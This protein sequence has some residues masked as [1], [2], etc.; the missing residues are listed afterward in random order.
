MIVCFLF[1]LFFTMI[2][3][4]LQMV[5]SALA[6]AQSEVIWYIQHVGIASSKSK[7]LRPVP[8]D[9]VSNISIRYPSGVAFFFPNTFLDAS[10]N[11]YSFSMK[12]QMESLTMV[13]MQDATDPTIGFLLDGIDRLCC[14][15]RKYIAG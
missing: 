15:V 4:F 2:V 8:V 13:S 5:F 1:F 10:R 7:A 14:L 12:V 11:S 3:Y 9:I 6:L